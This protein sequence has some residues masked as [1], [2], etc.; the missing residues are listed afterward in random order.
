VTKFAL[1]ALVLCIFALFSYAVT[2]QSN[3][4]PSDLIEPGAQ[5]SQ[6]LAEAD[7]AEQNREQ[8]PAKTIDSVSTELQRLSDDAKANSDKIAETAALRS[9]LLR[10]VQEVKSNSDKAT[11]SVLDQ[12]NAL[13]SDQVKLLK[14]AKESGDKVAQGLREEVSASQAKLV[15]QVDETLKAATARSE[16]LVQRVDAMKKDIDDVKRNFDEERQN[17]ST[18]S[19]SIAFF[20]ALAALILGPFMAY[21]FNSNR[22]ARFEQQ[23]SDAAQP[24][25][26]KTV[27]REPPLAAR[28]GVEAQQEAVLHHEAPSLGEEATPHD[29]A[30][31]DWQRGSDRE[32]V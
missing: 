27:E 25:A 22:L 5:S 29:N 18:I 24:Q 17:T 32:K 1:S 26:A 30:N 7:K 6:K 23:A 13:R 20:A 15:A 10:L 31:E 2:S 21:Q 14:D 16:A 4:L 12:I 19:P 8:P 28:A 11:Q 3:E 9:D